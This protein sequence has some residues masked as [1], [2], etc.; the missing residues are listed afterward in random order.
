MSV[1]H[2]FA[3]PESINFDDHLVATYYYQTSSKVNILEAVRSIAET[4]SVGTWV[5]LSKTIDTI[6][7][8]HQGRVISLWE[9]PDHENSLPEGVQRRNWIFQVAYPLHNF[10]PQLPLMLTTAFGEVSVEDHLKLLDIHFPRAYVE[11]FKGPKFG[12]EGVRKLLGVE[13]RPLLMSIIKPPLGLTPQESAA[14]FYQ[15]ALGK[16]DLVKDDELLVSHPWSHFTDR[17]REHQNAARRVF[18][19]SGHKVLYFVNITDRPRPHDG[20]RLPRH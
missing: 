14:E 4:Q 7:Q 8:R 13:D 17:I 19:E 9:A 11:Q 5:S 16:I 10:G 3:V 1:S 12:V 15:A 20:K 18:E 6:R 2:I